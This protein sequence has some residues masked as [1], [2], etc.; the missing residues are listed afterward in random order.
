MVKAYVSLEDYSKENP[1]ANHSS[2]EIPLWQKGKPTYGLTIPKDDLYFGGMVLGMSKTNQV[3]LTNSGLRPLV[4]E[5]IVLSGSGYRMGEV[6]FPF[7]I[8]P[9][10]PVVLPITLQPTQ[11]GLLA[12]I[13]R[14]DAGM[15][16][17]YQFR[18]LGQG[19]WDHLAA[20]TDMLSGLWGFLQRSVQ[21]AIV[22]S[23]PALSLS[24][25]AVEF[26]TAVTVDGQSG[27]F[28]YTITNAGNQPLIIDNLSISGDFEIVP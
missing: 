25:T 5:S 15:G 23:G 9:D 7:T 13:L 27:I 12:A 14:I 8:Y 21:P 1:L 24:N 19:I 17:V 18:L 20:V 16:G 10:K 11:Y 4:V 6:E 2:R 26:D 3:E 22:G 28:T